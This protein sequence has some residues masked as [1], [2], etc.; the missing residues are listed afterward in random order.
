MTRHNH[1]PPPHPSATDALLALFRA[2]RSAESTQPGCPGSLGAL[3][4]LGDVI[5]KHLANGDDGVLLDAL[6]RCASV[7]EHGD[8][9]RVIHVAIEDR[10]LAGN[11]RC[12]MFCIP[13]IFITPCAKPVPLDALNSALTA[14]AKTAREAGLLRDDQSVLLLNGL[15]RVDDILAMPLSA[16]AKAPMRAFQKLADLAHGSQSSRTTAILPTPRAEQPDD[17]PGAVLTARF[18]V[19][20]AMGPADA[21]SPL[22]LE[23]DGESSDAF[24]KKLGDWRDRIERLVMTL[25]PDELVDVLS[26]RSL[27]AGLLAGLSAQREAN[28]R[29]ET[30]LAME[31]RGLRPRDIHLV[32]SLHRDAKNH[33]FAQVGAFSTQD[34]ALLSGVHIPLEDWALVDGMDAAFEAAESMLDRCRD[35]SDG[36]PI[37]LPGTQMEDACPGCGTALFLDAQVRWQ[38]QPGTSHVSM[39]KEAATYDILH[40]EAFWKNATTH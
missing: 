30:V 24:A 19:G 29:I 27:H 4:R 32:A 22:V 16:L 37:W 9:L 33:A 26:P 3:I 5:V 21:P 18:L 40:D 23:T 14:L 2:Y 36:Q 25:L 20:F 31:A 35:F 28:L 15:R 7:G 10:Q 13:L 38:H 1:K 34:G 11:A 17:S 39:P 8:L 6:D 12:E